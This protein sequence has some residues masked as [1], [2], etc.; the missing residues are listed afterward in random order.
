LG[1][2]ASDSIPLIKLINWLEEEQILDTTL[3]LPE[4]DVAQTKQ[5]FPLN[6]K[7]RSLIRHNGLQLVSSESTPL[8]TVI[9]ADD[10]YHYVLRVG[11]VSV[12]V[13]GSDNQIMLTL[14]REFEDAVNQL[15]DVELDI[16]DIAT[17]L[18]E[19]E[20]MVGRETRQEFERLLTAA[21]IEDLG[22]LDEITVALIAAAQS[23]AL[24]NDLSSWASEV[25][26]ASAATLSRRKSK[27]EDRSIIYTE[28]VPIDVGRPKLWLKLS[29]Q[30]S[31]VRIKGSDLGFTSTAPSPRSIETNEKNEQETSPEPSTSSCSSE[32]E[33]GGE[34]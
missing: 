32:N 21:E 14:K 3:V 16:L 31:A 23:G 25:G 5:K 27:L 2:V 11:S 17:L 34:D 30:V 29:E 6:S 1:I 18:D 26:L 4:S 19:L 15:T 7:I 20:R 13:G 28:K 8:S 33:A 10:S 24:L 9:L 22:A 12:L